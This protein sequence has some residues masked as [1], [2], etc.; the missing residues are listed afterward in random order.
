MCSIT[1]W[2]C[3]LRQGLIVV[4]CVL[5]GAVQCSAVQLHALALPAQYAR[6]DLLCV[7]VQCKKPPTE[8][9][10]CCQSHAPFTDDCHWCCGRPAAVSCNKPTKVRW[11]LVE[12]YEK[13][14]QRGSVPLNRLGWKGDAVQG[15]WVEKPASQGDLAV[16]G[17][18][19]ELAPFLLYQRSR[20]AMEGDIFHSGTV[21]ISSISN[22][23]YSTC[24]PRYLGNAWLNNIA[25]L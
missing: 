10:S 4:E 2:N 16:L 7:S 18:A 14:A 24:I 15:S 25:L 19:T 5:R 17:K 13:S 3:I 22:Y 12:C 11:S 23:R 20:V 9:S 1:N 8:R 6:L 21:T